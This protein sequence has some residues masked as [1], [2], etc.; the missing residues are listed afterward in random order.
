MQKKLISLVLPAY[1]E[2][3][4][5]RPMYESLQPILLPLRSKYDF[6]IIFVN[7]GSPD[8]T[9]SEIWRLIQIDPEVKGINFSRNFGK[10]IALTAGVEKARGDAIITLDVDGQHPVDQIPNFLASWEEGYQV[11]YNKRPE[12]QWASRFK[13]FS[14]RWF[15]LLFNKIADMHLES[16]TTDYRL[17][18][19][20]VAVMFAQFREKKR[21]YRG[22]V[23]MIGFKRKALVFD[24]LPNPEGR[25][26]SYSYVKLFGLAL[27]TVTSYSSFPLRLIGYLGVVVT[28]VSFLLLI[29]M[30][31]D[32]FWIRFFYFWNV[33]IAVAIN[34]FL[35]G[36][37]MI[38]MGLLA[39]YIE[40]IHNEVVDRP[41]Y[42][43]SEEIGFEENG[44]T[45]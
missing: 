34:I 4:S 40:R 26:A 45:K 31:I 20:S 33:I 9:W 38:G 14:S 17:I 8:T 6:E 41:L 2:A 13:K 18:D 24:A 32:R 29:L 23:D 15:Y 19:R 28:I 44:Q 1:R 12:I 11:V 43:C 25:E 10:E 37:V 36:I 21:L 39:L 22:I 42:I 7:D 3:K 27:N 35:I 16:G 30:F 5:I